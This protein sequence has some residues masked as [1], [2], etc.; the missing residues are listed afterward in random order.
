MRPRN[1]LLLM[2]AL[3]CLA[4]T[5]ARVLAQASFPEG[6]DF[7]FGAA[8]PGGGLQ[9]R[10]PNKIRLEP[11][12]ASELLG[13]APTSIDMGAWAPGADP[14]GALLS[15]PIVRTIADLWEARIKGVP[16]TIDVQIDVVAE[17]G[18]AG[19]FN[20]GSVA[21]QLIYVTVVP[22]TVVQSPGPGGSVVFQAGADLLLDLAQAGVAGD[23]AGQL[24]VTV[25]QF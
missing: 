9:L 17:D 7:V 24:I 3:L 23:Y 11:L 10:L 12:T 21:N 8:K 6:V 22:G 16:G 1:H 20:H 14:V 2:A 5:P 4:L 18:T 25:N 13:G 15:G 19:A